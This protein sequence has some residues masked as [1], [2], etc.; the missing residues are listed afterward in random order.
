MNFKKINSIA[1]WVVCALASAVYLLTIEPTA[2]F[3]DCGEFISTAYKLEVGHPPGA[4]LFMLVARIFTMFA[5][6]NV[7][8]VARMVNIFSALCSGFTIMLLFW[9]ITHLGR[10]MAA[11]AMENF[12][13]TQ[14]ISIIG[15]GVV[16]AL[17]YTFSDTFWFSAVE[18]EVYACSSLFTA[19]VFWAVLRWEDEADQRYATRWLILIAYLMGL[20]IGVHLLNLLAI[21]AIGLVM[22]HRKY[23]NKITTKGTIYAL[24]ASAA[25]LLVILY[26]IV[27]GVIQIAVWFELLFVKG[28]GLPMHTGLYLYAILLVGGIVYGLWYSVKN[29]KQVL[30]A[31]ILAVT[32]IVIGYSS[33]AALIIRSA[34]E[35]PM[36]QNNPQNL[37][38]LQYYLNREQYGDRP[39]LVGPYYNSQPIDYKEGKTLYAVKD[40]KY[41]E[42]GNKSDYI[43][44]EGQTTIFPRMFSREASHVGA[45]KEWAGIS[46]RQSPD[47]LPTFG[48][49]LRFFFSY[50]LG[51]MYGRYFMWNFA[52]RQNDIQGNGNPINGNW[53]SGITPLDEARL[54]PQDLPDSLNNRGRNTYYFLPLLLGLVGMFFQLQRDRPNFL[55][56]MMLFFM[57]GIAIVIYLNQTP[58]QPR[59]RDYAYAG[60]FYAFAIWIG[61][62]VMAII[63]TIPKEFRNKYS[64][65]AVSAMLLLLVPGIMAQQNRD[66]H[67]RSG[68]Y[69]ARDFAYNYLVTCEPNS[70]IFTNGDNDSFPLWYAQEVEGVAPDVRVVN[71]SYLAADWY[72]EQMSRAAYES[73]P[74]PFSLSPDQYMSGTR[75][76]LYVNELDRV[77]G[78]YMELKEVMDFVR[79]DDVRAKGLMATD[80]FVWSGKL[81]N[82]FRA[83]QYSDQ[84]SNFIPAKNLKITVDKEK[85]L[86][87]GT[88]PLKDSAWVVPEIRWTLKGEKGRQSELIYKNSMMV[89]DM[90]ANNNWERPVYF[91]VTVSPENYLNLTEYF[92]MDGLAY[93]FV[94]LK[95]SQTG[96]ID[97]EILYDKMMN[98]FRWGN[99]D[100]PKVYLDETNLRLLSHF[101]GNFARLANALT[102]EGRK[103]S[104]V[105]ALDRAYEAI[106]TYQLPLGYVDLSLLEQYY[107][108]GAK[109]KG[110]ALAETL[111]KITG[112]EMDYF[113]SFPKTFSNSIKSELQNRKYVLLHLC[114]ITRQFDRNL[115]ESYKKHWD[116]LFPSEQWDMM[117]QQEMLDSI[118]EE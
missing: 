15:S 93:R 80:G 112:E 75:D 35:P 95:A 10:K 49:N 37:F 44:K 45:Y 9:T 20:S 3:W 102:A 104:A 106:P 76:V 52:G 16:G 71:L 24:L 62:G 91:A 60:S 26:G 36:D 12:T 74:L 39:L 61:L 56:T 18:G 31:V 58:Y 59:E 99:I 2:S 13:P 101:R 51:F 46:E 72:I 40:G 105:M 82:D 54:G 27:P 1:G 68:R 73:K 96:G 33:Y 84:L 85:V 89:L 23:Q 5:G 79:S 42:I 28:M 25:V 77:K 63:E 32:V 100:D 88:V 55:V 17:A 87:N 107:R 78:R 116:T 19:L 97:A 29:K 6:G 38:N 94:P 90:L 34:A 103:D 66:D 114:N 11:T 115:F 57:T 118:S 86:A 7:E 43:Y 111:F 47:K 108:A 21:P 8:L 67:D 69:T 109:E 98:R 110:S 83:A 53:I 113:L 81:G 50:Q 14:I 64:A 30:N 65:V 70:I 22:Y 48:Q 92:R 117:F 41:V 4:P